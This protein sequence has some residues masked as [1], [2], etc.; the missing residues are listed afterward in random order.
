MPFK[1]DHL[2]IAVDDLETAVADYKA[3]GFTVTPGGV[4]ASGTTHNALVCFQ[5]GSYLEL[6]ALTGQPPLPNADAIDFSPLLQ[7]GEGI[8]GFALLSDDLDAD[9]TDIRSRGIGISDPKP[10]GRTR[11]DGAVLLWKTAMI[12]ENWSPFFIQDVTARP[13]RVPS[14]PEYT[15]HPNGISGIIAVDFAVSDVNRTIEYYERLLNIKSQSSTIML[16]YTDLLFEAVAESIQPLHPNAPVGF[17]LRTT[18]DIFNFDSAL[19]A[20]L[21]YRLWIK[22][23]A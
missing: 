21:P 13:L 22:S 12:G 23:H 5:D 1:L 15:T 9:V 7:H 14:K 3:K 16:E 19:F 17:G 6:L 4:H 11:P 8:V 2:I 20:S 18:L 10:G